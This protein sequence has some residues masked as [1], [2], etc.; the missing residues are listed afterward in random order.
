ML[1]VIEAPSYYWKGGTSPLLWWCDRSRRA[2]ACVM[3]NT[4]GAELGALRTEFGLSYRGLAARTGI[5]GPSLHALEHGR[6][7]ARRVT[8]RFL[9]L[10]LDPDRDEEIEARLVAAAG[11]DLAPDTDGARRWRQRRYHACV[12]AGTAPLPVEIARPLALHRAADAAEAK[13]RALMGRP[14]A[15]D[16]VAQLEEMLRLHAQARRL[17]AEAGPPVILD[18]G[19]RRISAGFG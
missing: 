7:R 17:R 12:L 11:G 5:T 3:P 2:R 19:G 16:D 1:A 4:L 13:V 15:L 8:L 9:A 18:I 10:G 6:I 14:G